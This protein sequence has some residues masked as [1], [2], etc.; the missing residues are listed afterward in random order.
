[1]SPQ[2]INAISYN[3]KHDAR[4]YGILLLL[5]LILYICI[6]KIKKSLKV[7]LFHILFEFNNSST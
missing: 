4:R 5:I 1:M 7:N 3:D 6:I 2:Y